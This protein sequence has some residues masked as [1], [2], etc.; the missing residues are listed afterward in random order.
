MFECLK[1]KWKSNIVLRTQLSKFSGGI[2]N[3]STMAKLDCKGH[4]I[5]KTVKQGK[6]VAYKIDDVIDWLEKHYEKVS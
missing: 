3:A 2:L 1:N 4:G 6:K 5:G